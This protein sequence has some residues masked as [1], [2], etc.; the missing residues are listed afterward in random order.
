[1]NL[2]VCKDNH[3]AEA[4]ARELLASLTEKESSLIKITDAEEFFLERNGED[5]SSSSEGGFDASS[6]F[7]LRSSSTGRR[8][9]TALLLYLN[10][11]FF[12]NVEGALHHVIQSSI[13]DPNIAVILVHEQDVAKGAC[14]FDLFF[15][16]VPQNLIDPPYRIFNDIAIPLYSIKEYRIV[17]LREMMNRLVANG[18]HAIVKSSN[19]NLASGNSAPPQQ[20]KMSAEPEEC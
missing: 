6:S 18:T 2:L 17:S 12:K 19:D 11:D 1:M 3:G 7:L 15:K 4:L 13:E 8:R 20:V 5:D 14:P 16:Q 10:Q 9:S